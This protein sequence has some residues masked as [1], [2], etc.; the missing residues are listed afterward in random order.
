VAAHPAGRRPGA[1][2]L[3]RSAGAIRAQFLGA[4]PE[5]SHDHRAMRQDGAGQE[6]KREERER[7]T[8]HD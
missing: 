5:I 7:W 1:P 3:L 8:Q 2:P 4:D 6:T